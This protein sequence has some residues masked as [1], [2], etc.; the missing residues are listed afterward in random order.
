MRKEYKDLLDDLKTKHAEET[1]YL[2]CVESFLQA[3]NDMSLD[4]DKVKSFLVPEHIRTFDVSWTD[5]NGVE[6]REHAWRVQHSHAVGVYKGG[7]RFNKGVNLDI[8]KALAFEQ[9]LKNSLTGLPLGGAKGGA[10]FDIKNRSKEETKRFIDAFIAQLGPF[11]GS[12]YDVPAGDLGVGQADVTFMQEAYEKHRQTKDITFTSKLIAA[13][14]SL[15]RSE[16]TGYGLLYMVEEAMKVRLNE[17]LTNKTVIISGSGNVAIHAA[18]KAKALGA[19]V[20]ALSGTSGVIYHPLGIDIALIESLRLNKLSLDTYLDTHEDALYFECPKAIWTLKA[21]IYLPCATQDEI[22]LESAKVMV[23]HGA[24]LVAEGSN[25]AVSDEATLYFENHQVLFLPGKAA[26]SGGV[27]VS[28]FE[29]VQNAAGV[30]WASE[31]VD[32]ELKRVMKNTF[33]RINDYTIRMN[34]PYE[35]KKAAD[36][37]AFLTVYQKL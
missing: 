13:G 20:V 2:A 19:K 14:G 25:L 36:I 17:T 5:D 30:S 4:I 15:L 9:S 8:L 31:K 18:Y 1:H 33:K 26:N 7:I 16:A 12:T 28:Y 21:D 35:V 22:D 10:T 37:V 24:I 3:I 29:M 27:A 6:H 23:N 11:L 32:A 34:T